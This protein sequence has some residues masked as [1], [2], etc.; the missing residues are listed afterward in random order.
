MLFRFTMTLLGGYFL[1]TGKECVQNRG[2]RVQGLEQ[3]RF[4]G[5]TLRSPTYSTERVEDNRLSKTQV[6]GEG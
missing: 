2:S 5:C 6:P 1:F 3:S 4:L